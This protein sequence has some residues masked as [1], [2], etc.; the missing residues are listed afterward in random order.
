MD[1]RFLI[2]LRGVLEVMRKSS[3]G[4]VVILSKYD[5]KDVFS[6]KTTSLLAIFPLDCGLFFIMDIPFPGI[7]SSRVKKI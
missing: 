4:T 2:L 7:E 1:S 3:G 6:K 5:A